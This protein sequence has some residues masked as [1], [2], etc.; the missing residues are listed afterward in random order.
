MDVQSVADTVQSDTPSD[1]PGDGSA[2]A[3]ELALPTTGEISV[4]EALAMVADL[5]SR[6]SA[7]A[8]EALGRV[9]QELEQILS[10]SRDSEPA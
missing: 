10:D 3:D 7:E 6:T 9:L 4:D 2:A 8:T 1:L 5:A